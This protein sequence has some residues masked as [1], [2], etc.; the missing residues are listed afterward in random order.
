MLKIFSIVFAAFGV[1][2]LLSGCVT[3][4]T[5]N[6]TLAPLPEAVTSFGAV[7]HDGWLY[8][9]GGHEGKRHEYSSNEV[10][11]AFYR[12]NLAEG[13]AWETL[14]PSTPVQSPVFVA[15]DNF[16]YRVGGMSA[17]NP[18][19][20]PNNVWSHDDAAR[21]SLQAQQWETL[22]KLPG[23]RSSHDGWIV[24]ETL[25]IIGGWNL[26]G[27]EERPVWATNALILDLRAPNAAWRNLPQPFERRGLCV[28]A[29]GKKLY[30]IGGMDSDATPTLAVSVLDTETLQWSNGPAL[31]SGKLKGFGNSACV[32]EG[33]LYVSGMSGIVWRL[34]EKGDGWEEAAKLT[35]ARFFH[36]LVPGLNGK[37]VALGGEGV[38]G[39]LRDLE[40]ISVKP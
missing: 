26:S 18:Q 7:T 31:P 6:S 14:S 9:Y 34:N 4:P 16:I 33:R 8:V 40:T 28:A 20:Q 25:F 22:P 11:G 35:Q 21:F 38:A 19:G 30:A 39:K 36:R 29:L 5:A 3:R 32:A 10:S 17:R 23:A 15:D 13:K 37:L 24:G 1:L 2:T 27:D 12:L